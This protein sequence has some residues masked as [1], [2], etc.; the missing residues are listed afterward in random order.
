MDSNTRVNPKTPYLP[1]VDPVI[2]PLLPGYL[3]NRRDD[4]QRLE[5]ALAAKDFTVLRTLGHNMSGSGAAY[6]LPPI[7]AIG[8]RIEEAAVAGDAA[9]VKDLSVELREF[10][11]VVKLAP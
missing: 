7:S 5:D 8:R 6:G 4:L 3:K 1:E 11:D 10:L 2:L 9:R